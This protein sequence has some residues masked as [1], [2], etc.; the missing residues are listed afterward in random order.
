MLLV[1]KI[2]QFFTS[3]FQTCHLFRFVKHLR[4]TK[5]A[6]TIQTTWRCHKARSQYLR[7]RYATLIIQSHYRGGR[8]RLLKKRLL[9]EVKAIVIQR[10]IRAF[11]GRRSF[12][13]V[14]RKIV[15]IQC[16]VRRLIAQQ[17][18]KKLKV[19]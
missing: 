6:I 15:L 7:M 4:R 14:R 8:A 3:M 19:L 10:A 11:L 1:D 16:C 12:L 9:Y 13:S 5:A 2:N 17:A 18:L